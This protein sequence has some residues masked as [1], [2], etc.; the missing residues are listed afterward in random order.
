MFNKRYIIL[1]GI[2]KRGSKD[3]N[4]LKHILITAIFHTLVISFLEKKKLCQNAGK[5]NISFICL[6]VFRRQVNN[7]QDKVY[8]RHKTITATDLDQKGDSEEK[9]I[10]FD[11]AIADGD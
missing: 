10:K 11:A 1:F 3:L 9:K 8:L 4:L 5:G 2:C 7:V 6:R